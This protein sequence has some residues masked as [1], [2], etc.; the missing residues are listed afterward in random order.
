[1]YMAFSSTGP[2]DL[3]TIG[4]AAGDTAPHSLS[5]YY[6]ISFTDGTSSP[7]AG[8]ISISDFL[9]KTIG[10]SNAFNWS[11]QAKLTSPDASYA[12]EFGCSVS[13]S[14]DWAMVGSRRESP[15]FP[16]PGGMQYHSYAGAVYV[17]KRTGTTWAYQQRLTASDV[18]PYDRFGNSVSIDGDYAIVG[19]P[20]EDPVVSGRP[21]S[22]GGAAYI[23][24]RSGTTWIEQAKLYRTAQSTVGGYFGWSVDISG[25]TVIIGAYRSTSTS[26]FSTIYSAGAAYIYVRSG[27]TWSFQLKLSASDKAA[28]DYFGYSVSID[29]NYAIAGAYLEDPLVPASGGTQ[30]NAGSAYVFERSY[31]WSG[32]AT[33][34]QVAKLYGPNAQPSDLFGNSVSISGNNTVV[35]APSNDQAGTAAGAAYVFTRVGGNWQFVQKLIASDAYAGDYFGYSVAIEGNRIIVGARNEDPNGNL[36][37]GCAYV[38]DLPPGSS[39]WVETTK[40]I[41]S[42]VTP[43]REDAGYSV[44][45]SGNSAI[46]GALWKT[47][48][49][50]YQTNQG[51]AYVH[52]T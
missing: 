14:G 40:L 45:L 41:A 49:G 37:A 8:T 6:N 26:M 5:E 32:V 50:L 27:T 4:Q 44:G 11:Q 1:M 23:F 39:S 13:I 29:G 28:Y 42:D 48:P 36:D 43:N 51:A 16:I 31:T 2:L 22:N 21:I 24:H 9:G 18:Q 30:S 15:G 38:F 25:D 35:G 3:Q 12:D 7:S 47:T 46:V 52:T 33:W 19:A 34:S 10:S 20:Y 17:F